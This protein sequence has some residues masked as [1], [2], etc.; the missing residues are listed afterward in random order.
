[1]MFYVIFTL[2]GLGLASTIPSPHPFSD[3]YIQEINAKQST[4]VAGKNFEEEDYDLFKV[5]ASG[6]K[7]P[8]SIQSRLT[9]VHDED[10][11]V[12]DT[13]DSREAWPNCAE[14]IGQIRDQSRCGACWVSVFFFKL[15]LSLK[16][17]Q[18]FAAVEAMSDRIC[19]HSNGQ[20][21]VYVS[22]QDLLTCGEAGGCD[23]GWPSDAWSD[24]DTR[25]IVTG[26]LYNRTDQV[27][28]GTQIIRHKNS[29]LIFLSNTI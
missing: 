22:S 27:G 9:V 20:R 7:R 1:M 4:W 28:F 14:I 29:L 15:D 19:I 2:F 26:G 18:A 23:G 10:E 17:I 16:R 6:A 13:F 3:E 12:P 11:E 8:S 5:L 25:G 21:K 24:W